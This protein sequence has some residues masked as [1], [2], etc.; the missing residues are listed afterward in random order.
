MVLFSRTIYY[1]IVHK[2]PWIVQTDCFI[3]SKNVFFRSWNVALTSVER[4][5][6]S[7][8]WFTVCPCWWGLN[9]VCLSGHLPQHESARPSPLKNH[10]GEA[11]F[12]FFFFLTYK[13][14]PSFFHISQVKAQNPL[15]SLNPAWVR[16]DLSPI[17]QGFIG[18]CWLNT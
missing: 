15:E 7:F 2:I 16:P 11:I 18:L 13:Q 12:F 14:T 10:N 3:E 4:R 9:K 5:K 6:W 8:P 17:H 1:C